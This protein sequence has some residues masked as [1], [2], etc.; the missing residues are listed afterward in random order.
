MAATVAC[1]R[2]GRAEAPALARPPL[3]GK[4]GQEIREKV[5][6][7]CWSDW[8]KM[9]VMVINELRLNFIDPQSQETLNKHMREFLFQPK[10]NPTNPILPVEP[11]T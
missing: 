10:A 8:Q 3:P 6:A 11:P 9:E 5:C 2:C 4:L 7:D 1:L